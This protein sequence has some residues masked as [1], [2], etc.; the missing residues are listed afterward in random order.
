[1]GSIQCN[2]YRILYVFYHRTH[3]ERDI[4]MLVLE[5]IF[6]LIVAVLCFFT[7]GIRTFEQPVEPIIEHTVHKVR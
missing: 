6:A 5:N 2:K 4:Q 1:M 7:I 3:Y